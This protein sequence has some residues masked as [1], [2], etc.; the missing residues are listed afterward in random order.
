VKT[1][2][3]KLTHD[4]EKALARLEEKY[5]DIRN[6]T[7]LVATGYSTGFYCHG[8]G[9]IGKSYNILKTL[10]DKGY[11]A[12][13]LN[14]KLTAPGFAKALEKNKTG[15]FVIEDI[16]NVFDDK[17][18]LNLLRSAF[19]GQ[20]DEKTGKMVRPITYTTGHD[21]WNFDFT[22]DGAIIATGNRPLGDIPELQAVRTRIEVYKLETERDE[23][24]AIAKKIA[25]S[26]FRSDKGFLPK[27][28][29]LEIFDYYKMNLPSAK[30]P[31]LR[32]LDRAYSRHL[33]LQSLCKIDRWQRLL[34][35]AI[36]ESSQV[37]AETPALRLANVDAIAA[38]LRSKYG[39]DFQ[40][41]LPEWKTLTG[42]GKTAYY[43]ALK[44]LDKRR[45]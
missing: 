41:I 2:D 29:C 17:P 22:F 12:I 13:L 27:E 35:A 24:L 43:D 28:K 1:T 31:D 36:H 20:R 6:L 9:G 39:G 4:E 30:P 34:L 15:L 25:L 19:W 26:G 38:D 14:T 23:V 42:Q 40:R 5:E 11:K 33:G 18:A 44:R 16:E 8:W 7:E 21:N 3:L 45:A 10:K 32:I 37:T